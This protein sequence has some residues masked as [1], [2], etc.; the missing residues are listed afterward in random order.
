KLVVEPCTAPSAGMMIGPYR[1]DSKDK[2]SNQLTIDEFVIKGKSPCRY[3]AN[4]SDINSQK[5]RERYSH[6][7]LCPYG[8]GC[9]SSSDDDVHSQFFIHLK[10]CS[11]G[12]ECTNNDQ[13]HLHDFVH[14]EY[15]SMGG[16]CQDTKKSHLKQYRHLPLCEKRL[17]CPDYMRKVTLHL[18]Q[19]RH[20]KSE[21]PFGHNCNDFHDPNHFQAEIHPFNS[22]CPM[23]PFSCN[24]FIKY[25][26]EKDRMTDK[27]EK[28]L[29]ENHCLKYSHVCPWGRQCNDKSKQHLT[30][31][32]HIARN[33]CPN[34]N[35]CEQLNNE[36][37]LNSFTH[38]NIKDLRLLCKYSGTKCEDLTKL[39]HLARYRHNINQDYL[40]V[41]Q[42]YDLN[43]KINFVQN[44]QNLLE[45]FPT[46]VTNTLN[47]NWSSIQNVDKKILDWIRS[48]QP[49]HRCN[50]K[51]FESILL[52]GHVMGRTFMNKLK[53]PENVV[54]TAYNHSRIRQILKQKG[55]AVHEA[56]Q[57]LIKP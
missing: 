54:Q 48:L 13:K 10:Q 19:Y 18:Q 5:H 25:L 35:K 30:T 34:G 14:V 41:A 40:D 31:T 9:R 53:K 51:I 26:Q 22:P 57:Q 50:P 56:V 12:G 39:T 33:N 44:Y 46:Y 42:F 21:C 6:P 52:H 17:N 43:K 16:D 28:E 20:C 47:E 55:K 24:R 49:V 4:C 1:I 37:H 8:T 2:N 23:T 7:S 38:P 29:L 15:C 11:A 3:A 32:I 36:E 45:P 27:D